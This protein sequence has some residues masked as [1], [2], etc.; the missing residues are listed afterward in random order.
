MLRKC[1]KMQIKYLKKTINVS[2]DKINESIH[3]SP[4]IV[5]SDFHPYLIHYSIFTV[6]NC[7]CSEATS[8]R[9]QYLML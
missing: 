2:N 8:T 4:D 3:V 5:Q 6:V 1:L 9:N 7:M